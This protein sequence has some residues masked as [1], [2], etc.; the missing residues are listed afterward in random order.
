MNVVIG[1]DY[2]TDIPGIINIDEVINPD[3]DIDKPI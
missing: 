2:V 3:Y 1:I